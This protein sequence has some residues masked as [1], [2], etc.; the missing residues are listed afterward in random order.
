[1]DAYR[2]RLSDKQKPTLTDVTL[3]SDAP[4]TGDAWQRLS[5]LA[6]GVK[7]TRALVAEPANILYPESFVERCQPLRDLGIEITVLDET[8]MADLGMGALLGVSHG[9]PRKSSEERRVGKEGV[10]SCRSRGS[11]INEKT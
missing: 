1:M 9:S 4:S 5:A 3:V 6:D 7:F 10:R 11:P 8:Q 2:T